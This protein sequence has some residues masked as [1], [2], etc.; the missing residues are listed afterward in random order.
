MRSVSLLVFF[1]VTEKKGGWGGMYLLR[2]QMRAFVP[3]S[4]ALS[5]TEEHARPFTYQIRHILRITALETTI[6]VFQYS[7]QPDW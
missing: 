2:G 4:V 1:I 5:G 7:L 6:G 3:G